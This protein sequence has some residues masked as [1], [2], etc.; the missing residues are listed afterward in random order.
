MA[1]KVR[2]SKIFNTLLIEL[3]FFRSHFNPDAISRLIMPQGLRFCTDKEVATLPPKCHPF[4]LTK[5]DGE[6]SCGLSL[7]FYEEVKD[8]NICHAIHTLQVFKISDL[9]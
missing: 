1:F 8:I 6:K 9:N 5:E 2:V 4:L 3:N 7:V